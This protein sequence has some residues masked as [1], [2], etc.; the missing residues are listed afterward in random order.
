MTQM[1]V[2][3][4]CTGEDWACAREAVSETKLQLLLEVYYKMIDVFLMQIFMLLNHEIVIV[5]IKKAISKL[6]E[7]RI[8]ITELV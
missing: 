4:N 5:H 2:I 1:G 7:S 6:I 8:F 3:R